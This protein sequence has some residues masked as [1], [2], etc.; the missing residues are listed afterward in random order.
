MIMTIDHISVSPFENYRT[1]VDQ[2]FGKGTVSQSSSETQSNPILDALN[3]LQQQV[4]WDNFHS[5]LGRLDR[6]YRNHSSRQKL[7]QKLGEIQQPNNWDG[8]YSEIVALDF[9]QQGFLDKS[10]YLSEPILI[11]KEVPRA[12]T[13]SE[14][15]AT[16][17]CRTP[18]GFFPDFGVYF[19]VKRI[20]T[21]PQIILRDLAERIRRQF[22]DTR[23]FI[24]PEYPIDLG[25]SE[26]QL[27]VCSI[28][29]EVL[30]FLRQNN[31]PKYFRSE[32]VADLE[33]RFRWESG[34][35]VTASIYDP[36]R[37]AEELHLLPLQKFGQIVRD[38]PFLL[39]YVDFPWFNIGSGMTSGLGD[40]FY[41]A[42]SRRLFIQYRLSDTKYSTVDEN[43][44]GSETIFEFSKKISGIMFLE[45]KSILC[46]ER[47]CRN[48]RSI[49][50]LNPIAEHPLI[51]SIFA[52]EYLQSTLLT[53]IVD[54]EYDNY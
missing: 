29:N 12:Q 32:H 10:S 27:R 26:I 7:G 31:M 34:V 43:F 14:N 44:S 42:F 53:P 5:R 30:E 11:D 33:F 28:V 19:D 3:S 4:F 15:V 35:S 1:L 21:R 54:F 37:L 45:D 17:G 18:D 48:V 20:P 50:F 36:Y 25:C 40:E 51:N 39:I 49:L 41:R 13:F 6:I 38:Y 52:R 16:D 46:P 23:L 22:G 8:A 24:S 47:D 9:L 2:I